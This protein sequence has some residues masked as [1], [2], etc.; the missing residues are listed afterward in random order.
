MYWELFL[1]YV[2]A[3][4]LVH[5]QNDLRRLDPYQRVR[6]TL[7][8]SGVTAITLQCAKHGGGG[9]GDVNKAVPTNYYFYTNWA[10]PAY[11]LTRWS[12]VLLEKLTGLQ[13]VKKFP[14]FY[15]TRKFITVFT[16]ARYLSLYEPTLSSLHPSHILKFHL[17]IILPSTSGYPQLSF[18]L[19][20]PH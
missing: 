4:C 17:N 8:F 9:G 11:L 14:A 13:L 1:G 6:H 19:G 15:G 2:H 12:R 16:S 10:P 5:T 18:S 20:F 7:G 3:L